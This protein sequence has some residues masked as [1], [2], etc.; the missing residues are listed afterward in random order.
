MIGYGVFGSNATGIRCIKISETSADSGTGITR[1]TAQA[2]SGIGT[3]I[4]TIRLMHFSEQTT[5]YL[6]GYQNS[7]SNLQITGILQTIRIY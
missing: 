5:I 3:A 6:I 1:T 4:Q 2:V 7:G